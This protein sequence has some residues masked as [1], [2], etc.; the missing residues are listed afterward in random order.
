MP[1]LLKSL[2]KWPHLINH[3]N[4]LA[5]TPLHLAVGWPYGVR[6]LLAHGSSVHARDLDGNTPLECAISHSSVESVGLLMEANGSFDTGHAPESGIADVLSLAASMKN[7]HFDSREA[8]LETVITVMAER[9]RDLESRLAATAL[10][11]KNSASW[12]Q[13]DR[14]LDAYAPHTE[15]SLERNGVSLPTVS[16]IPTHLRTVYHTSHLTVGIAEKLWQAGFRDID[17]PAFRGRTPLM[18]FRGSSYYGSEK[19]E[20]IV[21]AAKLITWLV[22]KGARLHHPQ[23]CPSD[24]DP[25]TLPEEMDLPPTIL[26]LHYVAA[27]TGELAVLSF[28]AGSIMY[29]TQDLSAEE[30]STLFRSRLQTSKHSIQSQLNRLGLDQRQ[31]LATV[32]SD[33]SYDNC[34]CAC[35]SRGCLASTMMLKRMLHFE[36]DH[37]VP[38]KEFFDWSLHAT[39][40]LIDL[41][42]PQN[43]C[44]EWLAAEIVRFHTFRKLELRHTCCEWHND[45][46]VTELEQEEME[47]IRDEDHDRIQLLDSLL[48]EFKEN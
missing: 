29:L 4:K 6:V 40:F 15:R 28:R 23:I 44:W 35:S 19:E 43:A 7:S 30:I 33:C 31:I 25:I 34:S 32:F 27:T 37:L 9:R 17:I 47:E 38:E 24:D 5:Q 39:E 12:T 1:E 26:A 18:F 41:I 3:G 16:T 46:P 8:V 14:V 45:E 10:T 11:R 20:Y 22:R 13:N 42:G 48:H 2:Q 36:D 21:I